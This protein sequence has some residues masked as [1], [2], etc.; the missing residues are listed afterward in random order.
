MPTANI[1]PKMYN[2]RPVSPPNEDNIEVATSFTRSV[3]AVTP[4]P[5]PVPVVLSEQLSSTLDSCSAKISTKT[6]TF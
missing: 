4:L 3:A 6:F 5:S 1:N 2:N